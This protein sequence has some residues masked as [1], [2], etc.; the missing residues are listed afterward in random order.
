MTTQT[1]LRTRPLMPEFG[2]EILDVDVANASPETV[3]Q[4]IDVFNTSG[5]ILL[6]NQ[7]LDKPQ[8]MA[9][10]SVFGE[11]GDNT[12]EEYVDPEF[13]KIYVISNKVVNGRA[14]GQHDANHGWHSDLATAQRPALCTLLQALEVPDEGSDTLVADMCG[15][16]RA[17]PAE[18]QSE[19]MNYRLHQSF[20]EMR[21]SRG[22]PV[23]PEMSEAMPDVFHPMVRRHPVDGRKALWLGSLPIGIVGVP[24]PQG[25]DLLDELLEFATQERFTYRH[26]WQVGDILIWDDRMT[27]HTATPYDMTKYTRLMHRTWVL[28][29]VPLAA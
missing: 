26:K 12:R 1:P 15:A 27:L 7:R 21:R 24:N 13:P 28:G 16:F 19:L 22:L 9:F 23:T 2:A 29:E 20:V 8:L 11:L 6:R 18:R 4:I 3:R 5:V 14:I 10:T 17:L 25:L